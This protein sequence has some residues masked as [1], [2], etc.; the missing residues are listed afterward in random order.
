MALPMGG[1]AGVLRA[2]LP[3]L[4]RRG[5]RDSIPKNDL[6]TMMYDWTNNQFNWTL[7]LSHVDL[8]K[9]KTEKE[10]TRE[11]QHIGMNNS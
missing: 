2:E 4:L 10:E 6:T 3:V 1:Q 7:K 11:K 5:K 9:G 8:T